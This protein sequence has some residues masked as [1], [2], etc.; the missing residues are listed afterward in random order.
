MNTRSTS[1]LI[2]ALLPLWL[3]P[4]AA[5]S[6]PPMTTPVPQ[7]TSQ[8]TGWLGVMVT[9]LTPE[10]KAQLSTLLPV[11]QGILVAGV[12]EDSPAGKAGVQQY[13]VLL[14][15]AGQKLYSPDQLASLVQNSNPDSAVT[16]EVIQQ[17]EVKT[18]NA[19][20][21]ARQPRVLAQTRRPQD[22]WSMHPHHSPAPAQGATA[23]DSFE[24]VEVTTLE[25]GRYRA[26]V[27]YK[28]Q[29]NETRSFTF[30]GNRDDI[31]RQI[32][33]QADLPMDKKH[34]LLQALNMRS[35]RPLGPG[36]FDPMDDF[37]NPP[38]YP[39][40]PYANPFFS[41]PF[42]QGSYPHDRWYQPPATPPWQMHLYPDYP[43]RPR[44]PHR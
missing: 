34:A 6:A 1:I 9:P 21:A 17:A 18:L 42:Y 28:D 3:Q 31:M 30:E 22:H 44:W 4:V 41:D 7:N 16:L 29:N 14:S 33:Q 26:S 19:T 32:Q 40:R 43:N 15:F 24:S 13:D 5:Q 39:Q 23:W 35:A 37:F 12:E 36:A 20:L 25:D 27:S 38:F 10:L 2:L 8:Q 11:D